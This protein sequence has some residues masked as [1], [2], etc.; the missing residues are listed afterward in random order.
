MGAKQGKRGWR[1]IPAPVF[2]GAMLAMVLGFSLVPAQAM[3]YREIFELDFAGSHIRGSRGNPAVLPLKKE[4]MR[5]YPGVDVSQL[6]LHRIFVVAR[7]VKGK[8]FAQLLVGRESSATYRIV[9]GAK[10]HRHDRHS[11][12]RV[13]IVNPFRQSWGP[14][15][16]V[17]SGEFIV[18][19]IVLEVESRRERRHGAF[20]LPLMKADEAIMR[21]PRFH[22]PGGKEMMGTGS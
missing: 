13:E 2:I 4:L 9:G 6:R 21:K 3:A 10:S 1:K 22:V 18:H 14:W 17:L 8:G 12:G 5:Q 7:P 19:K 11:F 15:Q 20:I 16:L